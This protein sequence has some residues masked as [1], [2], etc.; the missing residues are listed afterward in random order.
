MP[1]TTITVSVEDGEVTYDADLCIDQ[2]GDK[3][4]VWKNHKVCWMCPDGELSIDFKQNSP[5][6]TGNKHLT[7]KKGK[8]T[9]AKETKN[10]VAVQSFPYGTTVQPPGGPVVDDPD[11]EVDPGPGPQP[12][13]RRPKPARRRRGG[14]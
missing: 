6:K 11:L 8:R 14:K 2:N 12:G 7:A 1:M 13:G 5:F 9:E 3:I 10:V 4:R